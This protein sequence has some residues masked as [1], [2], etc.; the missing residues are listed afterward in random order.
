MA[1]LKS[2][3][4]STLLLFLAVPAISAE[5]NG[6]IKGESCWVVKS[7]DSKAPIIGIIKKKAAVTVEKAGQGW[8]KII[9]APIRDPKSGKWIECKECY[10]QE[11]NFTTKTP[12][13]W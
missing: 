2:I 12:N 7:P 5:L 10:I 3:I 8:L 1:Y 9:F 4:L 13:R 11:F 6:W